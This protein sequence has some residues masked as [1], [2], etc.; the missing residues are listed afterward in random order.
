M[1]VLA[2]AW[3]AVALSRLLLTLLPWSRLLTVNRRLRALRVHGRTRDVPI[4]RLRWAVVGT[5]RY[6][7]RATCLVQALAL[8]GLLARR[9]RP[10][11]LRLGVRTG[12]T[13]AAH[14]WVE[15]DG[16]VVLGDALREGY[17]ALEL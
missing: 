4:E 13:F 12:E 14:A 17:A 2:R 6:V 9:G 11:H 15:V 7:P 3:A 8:H 16:A 5:S 10:S 1:E